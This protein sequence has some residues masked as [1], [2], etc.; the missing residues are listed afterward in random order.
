M[1]RRGNRK[2]KYKKLNYLP[3][4]SESCFNFLFCLGALFCIFI[5]YFISFYTCFA[6]EQSGAKQTKAR[7]LAYLWSSVINCSKWKKKK[8][9]AKENEDKKRANESICDSP[10]NIRAG[11]SLNVCVSDKKKEK[12][13]FYLHSI[14]DRKKKFE[15]KK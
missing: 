8:T 13:Y 12:F 15:E 10:M 14:A 9:K 2:K 3:H 1:R 7:L 4:R 5:F 11:N 6:P